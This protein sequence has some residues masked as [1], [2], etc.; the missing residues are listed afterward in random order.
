MRRGIRPGRRR[1]AGAALPNAGTAVRRGDAARARPGRLNRGHRHSI[2]ALLPHL[3]N[4]RHWR[5]AAIYIYISQLSLPLTL[6]AACLERDCSRKREREKPLPRSRY[7]TIGAG[8]RRLPGPC[9]R[10]PDPSPVQRLGGD[11]NAGHAGVR[12]ADTAGSVAAT[13][14][15]GARVKGLGPGHGDHK[16]RIQ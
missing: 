13:P 9:C 15:T 7:A 2:V 3:I 10:S 5:Q 1:R 11:D 16:A 4:P 14:R 6:N 12:D 8:R